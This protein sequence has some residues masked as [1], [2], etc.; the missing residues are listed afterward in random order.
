MF[1][2]DI[3]ED[4]DLPFLDLLCSAD[5]LAAGYELTDMVRGYRT[6]ARTG[7]GPVAA[8]PD[9]APSLLA[10]AMSTRSRLRQRVQH[11]QLVRMRM[12][13]RDRRHLRRLVFPDPS[14]GAELD[15]SGGSATLELRTDMWQLL[16]SRGDRRGGRR[17]HQTTGYR[18]SGAARRSPNLNESTFATHDRTREPD[19]RTTTHRPPSSSSQNFAGR[20]T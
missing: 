6:L 3:R 19:K 9:P 2:D 18:F 1:D 8:A 13:G 5:D 10:L 17:V 11:S 20:L 16:A 7:R 14:D 15:R 12:I 4:L